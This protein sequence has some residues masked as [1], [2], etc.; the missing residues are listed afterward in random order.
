MS[1]KKTVVNKQVPS[2]QPTALSG[3]GPAITALF[4]HIG[5]LRTALSIL[6]QRL[7][8]VLPVDRDGSAACST[9]HPCHGDSRLVVDIDNASGFIQESSEQINH[10][11]SLL[12]I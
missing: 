7:D 3:A 4:E 12:E 8:P 9:G 5:E 6:V 1:T 2:N 11:V 10:I